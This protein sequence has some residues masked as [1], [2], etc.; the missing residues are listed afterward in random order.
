MAKDM[1]SQSTRARPG[2]TVARYAKTRIAVSAGP[3]AGASLDVAG[4]LVRVGTAPDNDLVLADDTVSRRHCEIQPIEGGVRVRDVGST[5]GVVAAG[6]RVYD[7][8]FNGS[9]T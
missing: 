4:T 9:V 2:L 3:S 1:I 7:A 5:N 8:V 6:V